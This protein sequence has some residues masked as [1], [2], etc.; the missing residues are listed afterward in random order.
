MN[1]ESDYAMLIDG[2]RV[3]TGQGTCGVTNPATGEE[4]AR[5]PDCSD[6]Q[7]DEAIAAARAAFPAWSALDLN[8]RRARLVAF[9]EAILAQTAPLARL[10]TQEQG[11]PLHE[12]EREVM[13]C[14][15]WLKGVCA[16]DLP[17]EVNEDNETRLSVT[18]RV[19]LGVV[20]AI[21]PWNFP[22]LLAMFKIGPALVTGNTMVLKPS[23]FTPLTTLRMAE[24]SRGIL[25][26]GVLNVICGED[27]LGPAMTAHPG[28]D[29]ISFTGSTATGRRVMGSSAATLKRV[30]LELGGNDAAIVL[31]DADVERIAPDLFWA[32][33]RNNGQICIATK[34]LYVHRS[35]Y[36]RLKEALVAYAGTVRLGD[37]TEQGVGLGPLNNKPQFDR[38]RDLLEDSRAQGHSFLFEAAGDV[39][40]NGYFVPVT[41]IDNPPEEARIVQEEQFGPV[42]PILVYEDVEEAIAR[43]NASE[44]GLGCSIWGTDEEA[45]A[46]VA[47]RIQSGTVWINE[48]QYL[49][50]FASF[51][52]WKQSGVGTEGGREGLV[53][54]TVPRTIVRRRASA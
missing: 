35:V 17:E 9:A 19:P 1:S 53:E 41:L 14:A 39:P 6:E 37:G 38:V 33:F 21:V 40:A 30:T 32:A 8:E 20:G 12:A 11:K 13:G 48:T 46:A 15:G 26:D 27:R 49:S 28:G 54:Y 18:Q 34:R 22:L 31:P 51:G 29:K 50:P 52:G 42:L 16:L 25:P 4:I 47:A 24:L 45:A 44:Y 3:A 36:A 7:L 2:K 23:P 43:A 5:V 10:L